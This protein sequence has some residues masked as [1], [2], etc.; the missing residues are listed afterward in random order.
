MLQRQD[1]GRL[2]PISIGDT[3]NREVSEPSLA[4]G[5][6]VMLR[7]NDALFNDLLSNKVI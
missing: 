3:R 1:L 6:F 5:L 4:Q 7:G 2:G